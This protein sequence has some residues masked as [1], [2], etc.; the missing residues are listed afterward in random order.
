MGPW[1]TLTRVIAAVVVIPAAVVT[2]SRLPWILSLVPVWGSFMAGALTGAIGAATENY[3]AVRLTVPA[4]FL[5]WTG[6]AAL[7]LWLL[8]TYLP[9]FR[10][11]FWG[12][13]AASLATGVVESV[14]P[15]SVIKR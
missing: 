12:G 2:A 7:F 1:G 10:L 9:G 14:L 6:L 15:L 3:V 5:L 13:T 4:R 11:A 8:N